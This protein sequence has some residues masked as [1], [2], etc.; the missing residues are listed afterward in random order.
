MGRHKSE[1]PRVYK[2]AVALTKEEDEILNKL[3]DNINTNRAE[4]LRKCM[5]FA[6]DDAQKKHAI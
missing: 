4:T 6:Y 5:L 3:A 2:C 1:N